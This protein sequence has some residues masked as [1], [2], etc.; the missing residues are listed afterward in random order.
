LLCGVD[1]VAF[2]Q[3]DYLVP[4]G[5]PFLFLVFAEELI[6]VKLHELK[7]GVFNHF[8]GVGS[9]VEVEQDLGR[10]FSSVLGDLYLEE[11]IRLNF[12]QLDLLL[13]HI[14]DLLV[15]ELL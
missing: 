11:V 5:Y 8:D 4:E 13:V 3:M 15:N 9:S 2:P 7:E 10:L 12:Y 6:F 1:A 14:I